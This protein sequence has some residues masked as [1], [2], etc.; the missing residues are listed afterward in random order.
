MNP[1]QGF[2]PL[3][4][5]GGI[6]PNT[7]EGRKA[8]DVW[9]AWNFILVPRS[10]TQALTLA[11]LFQ[12]LIQ[13]TPTLWSWNESDNVQT[14]INANLIRSDTLMAVMQGFGDDSTI[15]PANS[16]FPYLGKN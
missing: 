3:P 11:Q 16:F 12:S 5:P 7:E 10:P 8:L 2:Q 4:P 13:K 14:L 6:D 1:P 9:I 15:R